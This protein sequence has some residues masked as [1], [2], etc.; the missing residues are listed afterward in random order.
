MKVLFT[1]N[2]DVKG[3]WVKKA[4][5]GK[6]KDFYRDSPGYH[7][8][9]ESSS[10]ESSVWAFTWVLSPDRP[11]PSHISFCTPEECQKLNDK[12]NMYN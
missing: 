12:I 8:L 3:A 11:L 4:V 1:E 10:S 5:D 9:Y 6:R 7:Q 2:G